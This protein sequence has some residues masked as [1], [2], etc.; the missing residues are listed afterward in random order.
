MTGTPSKCELNPEQPVKAIIF[1][2]VGTCLDWYSAVTPSF[3]KGFSLLEGEKPPFELFSWR[4][5][6]HWDGI[7]DCYE[8]GFPQEDVDETRRR[9][10][11]SLLESQGGSMGED[12]VEACVKAWHE[13]IGKLVRRCP[14]RD[15]LC[16]SC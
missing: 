11:L 1:D 3:R 7:R 16:V 14:E 13:Q 15:Y 2:L 10:L 12:A 6:A 8:A 9:A 5:R 4:Q